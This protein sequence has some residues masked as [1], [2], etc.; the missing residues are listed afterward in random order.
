MGAFLLDSNDHAYYG[1]F[2][3]VDSET[4]VNA[5]F[6]LGFLQSVW[7]SRLDTVT[8]T[9]SDEPPALFGALSTYFPEAHPRLCFW[10]KNTSMFKHLNSLGHRSEEDTRKLLTALRNA[11]ADEYDATCSKCSR[12]ADDEVNVL[13]MCDGVHPDGNRCLRALCF[14]Y[15]PDQLKGMSAEELSRWSQPFFCDQCCETAEANAALASARLEGDSSGQVPGEVGHRDFASVSDLSAWTSSNWVYYIVRAPTRHDAVMRIFL[16][17]SLRKASA[18]WCI[19][20]VERIHFVGDFY[21][22]W[23]VTLGLHTTGVAEQTWGAWKLASGSTRKLA[24]LQMKDTFSIIYQTS[25]T[26]EVRYADHVQRQVGSSAAAVQ[27]RQVM[28]AVYD[29]FSK[30]TSE[31]CQAVVFR[32]LIEQGAY[33]CERL[34]DDLV[35]TS[36]EWRLWSTASALL[37]RALRMHPRFA[38]PNTCRIIGVTRSDVPNGPHH[39]IL[40]DVEDGWSM[41][42]CGAG[43][44]MGVWCRH[45][46]A[47]FRFGYLT[48]STLLL[49]PGWLK[50]VH[51]LASNEMK[52]SKECTIDYSTGAR[53]VS[54]RTVWNAPKLLVDGIAPRLPGLNS[55]FRAS[56]ERAFSAVNPGSQRRDDNEVRRTA[57][58]A[59]VGGHS[60]VS[61][62]ATRKRKR[63]AHSSDSTDARAADDVEGGAA[64][65]GSD[66]EWQPVVNGFGSL[67][68][69]HG[70]RP[71][72]PPPRRGPLTLSDHLARTQMRR[73]PESV[74]ALYDLNFGFARTSVEAMQRFSAALEAFLSEQAKLVQSEHDDA[75]SALWGGSSAGHRQRA[76]QG[77]SPGNLAASWK[78]PRR[79]GR[80]KQGR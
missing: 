12:D 28:P 18:A 46:W 79:G 22:A 53:P 25:Q 77:T 9:L 34:K 45:Q 29:L 36:S 58:E 13:F 6:L 73:L 56:I 42:D 66:C 35:P 65:H 1:A 61:T 76:P 63:R 51:K 67:P 40:V 26:R 20:L 27:A 41:C 19:Q 16:L 3:F 72:T 75:T 71:T 70:H 23:D 60:G 50:P 68:T 69:A 74:L 47:A 38:A 5:G 31:Q 21:G 39:F 62:S 55:Q 15:V 2:A 48:F 14:S 7:G 64:V 32:L 17:C 54:V 37:W 52:T 8:I 33:R 80:G 57:D 4:S 24:D 49:F 44:R 43:M 10:H 59:I 11:E 78:R 30:F